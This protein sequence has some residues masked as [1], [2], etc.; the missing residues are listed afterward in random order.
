MPVAKIGLLLCLAALAQTGVAEEDLW[1]KLELRASAYLTN[2]GSEIRVDASDDSPGSDID[3]EHGLDLDDGLEELRV[4]VRWRFH[5][6][7]MIDFSYYD[8]SRDGERI[9]DRELDIGDEVFVIASR[10][11]T[12]L[13]FKVY[14]AS[15]AYS[16]VQSGQSDASVSFGLHTIDLGLEVAGFV[17]NAPAIRHSSDATVPLPVIGFQY[18]RRLG[19][20]FTLV[21][22]AELFALE[23]DDFD[24]ALFDSNLTLDIE[25]TKKFGGFLSLNWVDM[26]LELDNEDLAG[27][28][29][30]QYGAVAVG[31][32]L[33]F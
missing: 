20:P 24:G 3:L 29:E 26:N 1:P 11:D 22:D 16:F 33:V 7:H 15:Y 5:P 2:F 30:Y 27:E 28:I 19:G 25:L 18:S 4:D 9:I 32:R 31:V 21:F 8:I 10:L 6:R 14:K 23:F 13:D 12:R 17:Q